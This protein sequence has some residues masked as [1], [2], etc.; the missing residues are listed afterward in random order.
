MVIMKT[1]LDKTRLVQKFIKMGHAWKWH[2]QTVV[3]L[4]T[5]CE[6]FG[7]VRFKSSFCGLVHL[8]AKCVLQ[9]R[10]LYGVLREN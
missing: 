7:I 2:R 3:I 6:T 1:R 4:V 9:D 5:M 10:P 8:T